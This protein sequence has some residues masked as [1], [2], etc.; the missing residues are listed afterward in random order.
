MLRKKEKTSKKIHH[1]DNKSRI[2]EI[3]SRSHQQGHFG[4]AYVRGHQG[5]Q[6]DWRDSVQEGE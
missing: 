5:A 4:R 6:G 2:A 3:G 1:E